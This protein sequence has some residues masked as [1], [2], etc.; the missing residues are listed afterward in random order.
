MLRAIAEALRADEPALVSSLDFGP[1]VTQGCGSG[2]AVIIGDASEISLFNATSGGG[3]EYRMSLLAHGGDIVLVRQREHDF[4]DY[5]TVQ[6]G[7]ANVTFL[8]IGRSRQTSIAHLARKTPWVID[9]LVR[10][11]IT[12]GG[13]TLKAYIT[14]GHI[15]RLAQL[16]GEVAQTPI[17]VCGPSPRLAQRAND[18]LWFADLVHRVVGPAATPPTFFSFGPAATAA[19]VAQISKTAERL[20][21]KV[22]DSAGSAGNIGL[23]RADIEGR[24]LSDVR[25][26][27]L[28]RL[29][30]CGW[31]DTYPVLVGVWDADVVCSPSA[32][33]WIPDISDGPPVCDGVFEQSVVGVEGR[34]VGAARSSLPK[35][36]QAA[37][38]DQA[39]RLAGVL[40]DI[41]YFGRC[42][43]DAVIQ[44]RGS[45]PDVIHWIE[46]NGRWGGVSIPLTALRS[47]WG[48]VPDGLVITQANLPDVHLTTAEVLGRLEGLLPA[49]GKPGL[50]LTAPTRASSGTLFSACAVAGSDDAA[51]A[52]I[53]EALAR[54]RGVGPA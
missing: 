47:R 49:P 50:I 1:F 33:L 42:S 53:A 37:L 41:G 52:L 51:Q 12:H 45:G 10:M 28:D 48:T 29:R 36:T 6:P 17:H 44:R 31:A 2:P 25:G 34:F 9:R 7:M 39:V 43:L 16:I 24:S 4:E 13:L 23:R 20:V 3:L 15:W 18:K 46:C 19:L 11:A 26:F 32:Q 8:E 21:V 22:P 54:L 40:Q 38:A 5:L 35:S 14:T 27:L 30:G